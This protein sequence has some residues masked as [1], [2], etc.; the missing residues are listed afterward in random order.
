M[1]NAISGIAG[2]IILIVILAVS[3]AFYTI[4]ETQQVVLTQFGKLV[5]EP[6]TQAG[7][8]FKLPFVQTANYFEKRLLEWDG[9]AAQMPTR[10]K[11]LI[12]VDTTARWRISD[13]LKFMQRVGTEPNAQTRLDDIID[14]KTREAISSNVLIEAIRNSNRLLEEGNAETFENA[15]EEFGKTA[16][17][18]INKGRAALCQE[19][20]KKASEA[21]KDYGIELVDVRIKR[22]NYVQEVQRKVYE[23]MI[24]ERKRAAEQFRSEGQ[25]KKAEIEG[26]RAKELQEIQSEAYRKAQ[27]IKGKADAEAIAIYADAYN[28]DPGFYTFLKTLETYRETI[29][30]RTTLMLTTDNDFY[31]YLNG[32][33]G[34]DL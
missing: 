14:A 12:W 24:S 26:Q 6:R 23:R 10:E 19:I 27:E 13:A 22:I 28:K 11:R 2:I 3:G 21:F 5:G 9:D 34:G 32:V 7:L 18:P 8:Y 30:D 1:K 16:L 33:P 25:G 17:A 4:D 20:L 15:S 31:E 29:N